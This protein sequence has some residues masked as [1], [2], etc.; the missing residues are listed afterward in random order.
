VLLVSEKDGEGLITWPDGSLYKGNF[1]GGEKHGLGTFTDADG[2]ENI[3][4]YRNGELVKA[5][6]Q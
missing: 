4:E 1:K 5:I 2:K 3:L 6:N